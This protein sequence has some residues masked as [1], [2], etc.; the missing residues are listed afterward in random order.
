[1]RFQYFKIRFKLTQKITTATLK[2]NFFFQKNARSFVQANC[3]R[4]WAK[5]LNRAIPKKD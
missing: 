5:K 2:Q 4:L 1:M 3:K